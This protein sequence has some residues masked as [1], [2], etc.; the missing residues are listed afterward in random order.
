MCK[1]FTWCEALTKVYQGT[2]A[3]TIPLQGPTLPFLFAPQLRNPTVQMRNAKEGF[4]HDGWLY[5][6]VPTFLFNK[7]RIYPA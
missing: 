7:S 6:A 4:G 5:Q 1:G 2:I 3:V